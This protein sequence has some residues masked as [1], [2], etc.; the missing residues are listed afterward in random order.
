M[1]TSVVQYR[2][3]NTGTLALFVTRNGAKLE[4]TSLSTGGSKTP[5]YDIVYIVQL[6]FEDNEF[7]NYKNVFLKEKKYEIK[8]NKI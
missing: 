5:V 2:H 8:K 1:R 7:R 3:I 4:N 6:G